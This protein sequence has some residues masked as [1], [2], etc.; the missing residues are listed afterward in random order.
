MKKSLF[1]LF[2]LLCSVSLFTACSDDDDEGNGA[3][4]EESLAKQIV[5]TYN[6]ELNV[7][8]DGTPLPSSRQQIYIKESGNAATLELKDFSIQIGEVLLPV[9]DIIFP[10]VPV[11]N[12]N[13]QITLKETS[14]V[15]DHPDLKELQA[16][17]SGTE[18]SGKIDLAITVFATVLGQNIDVTFSGDKISSE[19]DD[20]DYAKDIVGWYQR[21]DLKITGIDVEPEYPKEG[22]SIVY[23]GFNKISIE[24]TLFSF[25][26]KAKYLKIESMDIVKTT[27]GFELLEATAKDMYETVDFT[28]K[29][30]IKN[31]EMT[32][33]VGIT[34]GTNT[35]EC[36]FT[37]SQKQVDAFM[38]KMSFNSNIVRVQPEIGAVD[39]NKA[40][41]VFYVNANATSDQLS[42]VPEFE[43]SSGATIYYGDDIYV[44]GTAIDFSVSQTFKVVAESKQKTT[45]YTVTSEVL[46]D[47]SFE[48]NFDDEWETLSYN[49]QGKILY[50]EPGNGWATSNGGVAYIKGMDGIL[51][52]YSPDKP[53]AVTPEDGRSGKAACL[54][55]LDTKG[56]ASIIPGMFPA[57]P[58]VTS[59]SVFSG[60]FKVVITNTLKS[61]QF[62]YPC[63]KEPV[64][65]SGTYKYKSGDVY[66]TCPD[67]EKSNEVEVTENKKDQPAIDAV[68]YEVD[69]YAFDHLDGTNLLTSDK[70][71]AIASVDG[72]EQAEYTDFNVNFEFKEGKSFDATKK[73]KL[74]IVCSSSKDGDKFSGAPGSVLY[75]DD[76]KVTF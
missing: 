16:T 65:F 35:A 49:N 55:T 72:K 6:G 60:I 54:T 30:N 4:V 51:H 70:I 36:E 68:L 5:G 66:Y 74:A 37:G 63:L 38:N 76:F 57:V 10:N 11:E 21:T 23:K 58:K 33:N 29:G 53:N 20:K 27:D 14:V 56:M 59:G 28:V 45:T 43:V 32:L 71:V 50:Q 18:K 73:Y 44:E 12:V 62:G 7:S 19:I 22:I 67:P 1:Y 41:V 3:P 25:V 15:I 2:A 24:S 64:A 31:G 52:C 48:T 40:N 42:L 39:K 17:L 13:G 47:F 46:P 9:G 75:V 8:V 26:E 69:S 34:D 61:T